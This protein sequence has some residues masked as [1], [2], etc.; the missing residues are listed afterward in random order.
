PFTRGLRSRLSEEGFWS[1]LYFSGSGLAE[2]A[3]KVLRRVLSRGQTDIPLY[4]D[5]PT[6]EGIDSDDPE[7]EGRVGGGG[8]AIDTLADMEALLRDVPLDEVRLRIPVGGPALILW[9]MVLTAAERR[10]ISWDRISGVLQ[11]D[12]PGEWLADSGGRLPRPGLLRIA[13]DAVAFAEREAPGWCAL[14][15]GAYRVREAGGDASQEIAF[16]VCAGLACVEEMGSRG[17]AEEDFAPRLG[18]V[19]DIHADFFEEIAKM[20]A[21]R[22]IWAREMR[23]RHGPSDAEALKMRL[24]CRSAASSLLPRQPENNMARVTWQVLAA[25]LGG[26]ESVYTHAMDEAGGSPSEE[27]AGIALR[28]QQVIANESGVADII[29]AFGGSYYLEWLTARIESEAMAHIRAAQD[30]GGLRAAAAGE[31]FRAEIGRSRERLERELASGAKV[32]VGVNKYADENSPAPS[33]AGEMGR[34]QRESLSVA[35]AGR[36]EAACRDALE[37]LRGAAAG[38][39]NLMPSLLDGVRASATVGEMGRVLREELAP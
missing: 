36:E 32:V 37:R 34:R 6:L 16:A 5:A 22:R 17:T 9:A 26:A 8:V 39:E 30:A 25:A 19:F 13:G 4:F 2:D 31:Y 1:P 11:D 27:A 12:G 24:H 28:T 18:F 14:S 21:A 33:S 38:G 29:D 20:R 3:N 15:I 23:E 7:A 35:R 10:G